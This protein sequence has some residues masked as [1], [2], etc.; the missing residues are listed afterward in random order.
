MTNEQRI[1]LVENLIKREK[2]H[3]VEKE[4]HRVWYPDDVNF[5]HFPHYKIDL[6]CWRND[7]EKYAYI[8]ADEESHQYGA[9]IGMQSAECIESLL[10]RYNLKTVT[11]FVD[12]QIEFI[13][14]YH[15]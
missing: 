2:F 11:E 8:N 1:K 10:D 12:N 6:C 9:V 15:I 7:Y 14:N 4:T 13:R 5:R 3:S